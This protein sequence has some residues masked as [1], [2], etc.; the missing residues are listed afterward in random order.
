MR[1]HELEMWLCGDGDDGPTAIDIAILGADPGALSAQAI[2]SIAF[3]LAVL[4]DM[5]A[6]D[7]AVWR[8]LWR[9]R[10][11]LGYARAADLLLAGD[12][13]R[14]E[15]LVTFQWNTAQAAGTLNVAP[16]GTLQHVGGT[17]TPAWRS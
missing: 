9:L 6:D 3:V 17:G 1:Q 10:P 7:A 16:G 2:R 11:D 5:Y 15:T 13:A 14:V 12:G 8:W 4:R